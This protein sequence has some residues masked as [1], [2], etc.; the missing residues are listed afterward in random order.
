[1]NNN[2]YIYKELCKKRWEEL[3]QNTEITYI[4]PETFIKRNVLKK[5]EISGVFTLSSQNYMINVLN[6]Y[7]CKKK[8]VQEINEHLKPWDILTIYWSDIQRS[9]IVE[10]IKVKF[11]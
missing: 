5:L 11:E 4:L 3:D 6:C 1:M 9:G 8:K 7:V 2:K 10:W